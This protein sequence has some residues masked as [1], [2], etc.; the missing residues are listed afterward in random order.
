MITYDEPEEDVEAMLD[1]IR[2]IINVAK[3]E[4]HNPVKLSIH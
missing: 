4:G 2:T 1:Q 3:S